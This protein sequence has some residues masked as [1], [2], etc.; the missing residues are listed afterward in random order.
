MM[1]RAPPSND[2]LPRHKGFNTPR[3][4]SR[5]RASIPSLKLID[6]AS[7]LRVHIAAIKLPMNPR[8]GRR[9]GV[10]GPTQPVLK[11]TAGMELAWIE[12]IRRRDHNS[13]AGAD[14]TLHFGEKLFPVVS[15][16]DELDHGRAG[17]KV[18][19]SACERKWL[20]RRNSPEVDAIRQSI[21]CNSDSACF[22][23]AGIGIES[24]D[25]C[26]GEGQRESNGQG[27]R[28]ATH[29]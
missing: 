24:L 22:D 20:M 29:V 10:A 13:A 6:H 17:D 4:C 19:G 11:R 7:R 3:N 16:S 14:Y 2:K 12:C 26:R 15:L 27:A 5:N 23:G 18:K 25:L 9:P 8:A 21:T 28:A 1:I